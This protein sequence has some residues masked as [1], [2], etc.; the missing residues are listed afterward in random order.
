MM[1]R[2]CRLCILAAAQCM[3]QLCTF[4]RLAPSFLGLAELSH[5]IAVF[6]EM[7]MML[8]L[9]NQ[10]TSFAMLNG[11]TGRPRMMAALAICVHIAA[12][13]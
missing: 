8:M 10:C 5:V 12:I 13:A 7:K 11:R 3:Y 4:P 9:Q 6:N 1:C 2:C